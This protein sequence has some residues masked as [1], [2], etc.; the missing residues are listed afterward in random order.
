[1]DAKRFTYVVG[2]KLKGEDQ[3]GRRFFGKY[4]ERKRNNVLIGNDWYWIPEII[5]CE[6][7]IP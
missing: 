3:A 1:M 6:K 2:D 7:I 5:K 4:H